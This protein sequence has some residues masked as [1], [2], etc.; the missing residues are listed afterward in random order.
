MAELISFIALQAYRT[1]GD[2]GRMHLQITGNRS[3]LD[4]SNADIIAAC[5]AH[6]LQHPLTL[7]NIQD[8]A[9]T[10]GVVAAACVLLQAT[11]CKPLA[12]GVGCC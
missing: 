10:A 7:H 11:R 8:P 9:A 4:W 12:H 2:W 1:R 5:I 6:V 3:Q